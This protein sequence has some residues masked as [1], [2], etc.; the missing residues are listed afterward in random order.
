MC[1]ITLL[2]PIFLINSSFNIIDII[3]NQV[4]ISNICIFLPSSIYFFIVLLAE[5]NRIPFDLPEAEAELVAG[6]N[7]EYSSINF[8]I[9]FLAE[10]TNILLNSF[11]FVYLF[12]SGPLLNLELFLKITFENINFFDFYFENIK[13]HIFV[14]F[15]QKKNISYNDSIT[16]IIKNIFFNFEYFIKNDIYFFIKSVKYV[17]I[18]IYILS[19]SK[20]N[21]LFKLL[22]L[23]FFTPSLIFFILNIDMFIYFFFFEKINPF[24]Q[25]Y[26]IELFFIYILNILLNV[27]KLYIKYILYLFSLFSVNIKTVFISCVFIL[28]RAILPRYRF[29]QL[30]NLC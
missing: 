27:Y 29:D 9:F 5:N 25:K 4:Y 13:E 1:F 17:I 14:I 30:M 12:M 10:Y 26:E 3:N 23:L 20:K 18:L 16:F 24:F 11:V 15:L 2:L 22:L 28:I 7:V 19:F 6:Y 8:A 21:I